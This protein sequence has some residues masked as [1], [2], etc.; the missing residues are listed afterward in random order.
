MAVSWACVEAMKDECGSL[1]VPEAYM[2]AG[3]SLGEYTALAAAK[4]LG[5]AES[6]LLVQSRG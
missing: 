5:V 1:G 3:H 4:V 6:V 2:M